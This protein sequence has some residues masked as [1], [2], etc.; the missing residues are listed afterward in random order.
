MSYL[1]NPR[2]PH[3]WE[4][5]GEYNGKYRAADGTLHDSAKAADRHDRTC[6]WHPWDADKVSGTTS[7]AKES[8][9]K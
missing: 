3:M 6:G 4:S 2:V 9:A 8:D 7:P 5:D 1:R